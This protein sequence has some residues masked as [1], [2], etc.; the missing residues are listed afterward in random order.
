MGLLSDLMFDESIAAFFAARKFSVNPDGTATFV[1]VERGTHTGV[2]YCF[3]FED[4]PIARTTDLI[5]DNRLFSLIYPLRP[6]RQSCALPHFG[7][8][9][10]NEAVCD[11]R[12]IF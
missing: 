3:V 9:N 6:E 8:F 7:L 12:C 11:L 2:I 1:P 5:Q 4:P 10:I